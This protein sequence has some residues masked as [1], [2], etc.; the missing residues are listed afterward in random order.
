MIFSLVRERA[1]IF[2]FALA[3]SLAPLA[4]FIPASCGAALLREG[5][6]LSLQ[7]RQVSGLSACGHG[8]RLDLQGC[9]RKLAGS[10]DEHH[11]T[12]PW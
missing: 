4:T 2:A 7:L 9:G 1:G 6:L 12:R 11:K 3:A 8:W 5:V 10:G